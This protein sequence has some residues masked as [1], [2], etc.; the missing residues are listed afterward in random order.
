MKNVKEKDD[1]CPINRVLKYQNQKMNQPDV[2][3]ITHAGT[4]GEKLLRGYIDK[5][6]N[7]AGTRN[8]LTVDLSRAYLGRGYIK[9]LTICEQISRDGLRIPQFTNATNC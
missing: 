2:I 4:R 5:V 1:P 8:G 7:R 6:K 9:I 3:I